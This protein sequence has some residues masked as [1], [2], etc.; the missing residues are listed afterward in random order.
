MGIC[1]VSWIVGEVSRSVDDDND[2][3]DANG[4]WSGVVDGEVVDKTDNDEDEDDD[5]VDVE[6]C[7]GNSDDVCHE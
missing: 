1:D 4:A 7:G 2:D 5:A 6:R 3:D